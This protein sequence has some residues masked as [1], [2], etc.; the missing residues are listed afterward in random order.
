MDAWWYQMY[1]LIFISGLI[2]IYM[3]KFKS[4]F[5]EENLTKVASVLGGIIAAVL[6]IS[7]L[8]EILLKL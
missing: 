5:T 4:D 8:F 3:A 1:M 7:L 6:I 2:V